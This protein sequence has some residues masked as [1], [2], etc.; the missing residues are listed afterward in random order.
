MWLVVCLTHYL[1]MQNLFMLF[2]DA[3]FMLLAAYLAFPQKVD[4][5]SILCSYFQ[6][7][8]ARYT[9]RHALVSQVRIRNDISDR[10][11]IYLLST[12]AYAPT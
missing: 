3:A 7:G 6:V 8:P 9:H 5:I 2:S 4:C 10:R 1:P 11:I 12:C